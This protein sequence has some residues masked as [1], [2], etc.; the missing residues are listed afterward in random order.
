MAHKWLL[1]LS[2]A[3]ASLFASTAPLRAD[4]MITINNLSKGD[5]AIIGATKGTLG[6]TA[7]GRITVE[8][9]NKQN[10]IFSSPVLGKGNLAFLNITRPTSGA[11]LNGFSLVDS[12][13]KMLSVKIAAP[14]PTDKLTVTY[15]LES[16]SI[17]DKTF[18][19][20]S[21]GDISIL[22]DAF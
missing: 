17:W 6:G 18:R 10:S 14:S 13:Q 21:S 19:V 5:W 22:K 9:N 1:H 16:K 12:K 3:G 15:G 11:F 20:E 8:I 7:S 2:I 4:D